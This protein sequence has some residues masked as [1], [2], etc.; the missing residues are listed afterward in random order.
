[1]SALDSFGRHD[2]RVEAET[3]AILDRGRP[4]GAQFL[5]RGLRIK[6]NDLLAAKWRLRVDVDQFE[7]G[8]RPCE[9]SYGKVQTRI[10]TPA[11][12]KVLSNRP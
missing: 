4:N 1:M 6:G 10:P 9:F 2:F 5:S 8:V 11:A 3:I 7:D 12:L